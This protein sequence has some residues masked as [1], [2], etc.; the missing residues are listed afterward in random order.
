LNLAKLNIHSL[1]G[2]FTRFLGA[3]GLAFFCDFLVLFASTELLGVNYL[4]S[5]VF[6][7]SV[8][9]LVSYLLAIKWVFHYRSRTKASLEFTMFFLISLAM[10]A[11]NEL[12]IWL[13]VEAIGIYY[14]GA[15]VLATG[16][17]FVFSFILKKAFLFRR[18]ER[19]R[20]M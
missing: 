15:K 4:L 7:F 17:T 10:L 14:L 19:C 11:S 9:L 3:G 8:G 1:S 16:F 5:N 6:G 20:G 13:L 12:A 18:K 2:E